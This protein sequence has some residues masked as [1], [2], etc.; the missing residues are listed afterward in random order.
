MNETMEDLFKFFEDRAISIQITLDHG[1][2][3][4]VHAMYQGNIHETSG[5]TVL[6]C[7]QRMREKIFQ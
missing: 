4:T 7:L 2:L 3:P 6:Y 1:R 5:Q